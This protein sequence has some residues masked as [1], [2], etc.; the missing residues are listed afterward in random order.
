MQKPSWYGRGGGVRFFRQLS[1]PFSADYAEALN[2]ADAPGVL[3]GW[4]EGV[5]GS[6][7][8]VG[9]E[10]SETEVVTRGGKEEGGLWAVAGVGLQDELEILR[11]EL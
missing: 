3:K 9:V 4:Q 11:V 5:R 6:P 7:L 10:A 2:N 8:L 1:Q